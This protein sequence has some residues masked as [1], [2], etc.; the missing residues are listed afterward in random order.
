M[1]GFWKW[2]DLNEELSFRSDP[3]F[4][5]GYRTA[6]FGTSLMFESSV[7]GLTDLFPQI[8]D[9][10][11]CFL[12]IITCQWFFTALS[13]RPGNSRAMRAH[14][15]PCMWWAARSLS[16][17]SSVNGLRL[18]LGSSWLN[19]LSLQ[20]FPARQILFFYQNEFH[21]QKCIYVDA[22]ALRISDLVHWNH[23]RGGI[24]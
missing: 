2:N 14:L 1:L 12:A 22:K 24:K 3:S 13:V 19:H 11:L 7:D 16:S 5:L 6:L 10:S 21:T 4:L 17:S 23:C 20:L 8:F 15:F 9:F 18:I